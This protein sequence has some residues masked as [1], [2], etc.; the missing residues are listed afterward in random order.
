M[1]NDIKTRF[2]KD[3]FLQLSMKGADSELLV[4]LR[5]HARRLYLDRFD[6]S[7]THNRSLV[8]ALAGDIIVNRLFF[9][10]TVTACLHELGLKAPVQLGPVATHY[11][12]NNKTGNEY[13][14]ALHQDYP[15]MA[16]SLNSIV[17]WI[18][19][20]EAGQHAHSM[21]VFPGSHSSG[22]L[23]GKQTETGY[24]ID[25]EVTDSLGVTK[26]IDTSEGEMVMFSPFLAHKT[27][28]NSECGHEAYKLSLSTR[29]SDIADAHWEENEFCNAYQT[30]VDRSLYKKMLQKN[31][32]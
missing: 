9:S 14:L 24:I 11:T 17:I 22:L 10:D 25:P 1:M 12:S 3:G 16:S 23:P 20:F 31:E 5:A 19:L 30:V 32:R 28:V 4:K 8:K 2:D 26:I 7:V 27:Y 21:E 29:F 15:S 13:G 6:D 18:S